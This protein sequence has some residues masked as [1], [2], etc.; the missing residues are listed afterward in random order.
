V[1]WHRH[2]TLA[3]VASW[4]LVLEKLHVG[5]ETPAVTV[6]QVREIFSRLLQHPPASPARIAAEVT[7]VLRC[8]EEARIYA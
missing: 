7:R 3:M 6:P 5:G 4:F 2:I 8:N 1:G